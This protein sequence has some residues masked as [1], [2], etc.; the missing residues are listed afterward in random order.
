MLYHLNYKAEE[1]GFGIF[2]IKNQRLLVHILQ[3]HSNH[4]GEI[5]EIWLPH[6]DF[7]VSRPERTAFNS[8]AQK[9]GKFGW[10]ISDN[11]RVVFPIRHP[12]IQ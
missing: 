5:L 9:I 2:L 12:T 6:Q 3:A 7:L 1:N 11:Y 10:E 4:P 8:H